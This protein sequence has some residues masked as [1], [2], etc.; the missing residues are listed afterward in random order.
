MTLPATVRWIDLSP[1]GL[2]LHALR[3]PS[4]RVALVVAGETAPH[5]AA[6][7]ALGFRRTRQ[8]HV[9]HPDPTLKFAD[10]RRQFPDAAVRELPRERVVR[11]APAAPPAT[12]HQVHN[13]T[14]L[15]VNRRGQ[16]VFRDG[17]ENRYLDGAARADFGPPADVDY[18]RLGAEDDLPDLAAGLLW[19]ALDGEKLGAADLLRLSRATLTP[20]GRP[21][22]QP[23]SSAP[24][25]VARK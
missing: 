10:V 15:G 16:T 18:L 25:Q 1:Y 9:V 21:S 7:A 5:A 12:D 23:R 14:A 17:A 22:P 19:R 20:P 11:V 2:A 24:S 4:G 8:G 3:L 13:A 6:L